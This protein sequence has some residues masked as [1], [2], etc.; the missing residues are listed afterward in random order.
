MS[1]SDATKPTFRTRA[2]LANVDREWER[3][4][5]D[6]EVDVGD[7]DQ[8]TLPDQTRDDTDLGWGERS[9]DDDDRLLDDRPPHY[10][11]HDW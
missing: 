1:R 4:D 5:D 6:R 2:T 10:D 7:D 11:G 3:S 9:S 8:P